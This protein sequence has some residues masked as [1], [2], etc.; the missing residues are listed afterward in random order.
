MGL[1]IIIVFGCIWY[2]PLYL[3]HRKLVQEPFK[4]YLFAFLMG[5]A[6]CIIAV[7]VQTA[8]S[9]AIYQLKLSAAMMKLTGF[10]RILIVVAVVEELLK[11]VL[12]RIVL[13]RVPDLTQAGSMLI[14]AM[15]GI[16][17]D[18][19]ESLTQLDVASAV[20]RGVLMLH[21]FLQ[22]F[23]GQF[24]WR[25]QE[26]RKS[27]DEACYKKNMRIALIV[28]ILV[29]AVYDYCL[30]KGV[31]GIDEAF[32]LSLVLIAAAFIVGLVFMI[33]TLIRARKTIKAEAT[34]VTEN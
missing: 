11:F 6:C 13:K 30:F 16:G 17:F 19:A 26:A 33:N 4:Y 31:G 28:P 3:K 1:P 5:I 7:I 25:A 29:H 2:L 22:L 24:W 20:V 21:L 9:L 34:A 10:F 23:M 15:T 12:G 32:E 14:L 27:G 18:L 8:F